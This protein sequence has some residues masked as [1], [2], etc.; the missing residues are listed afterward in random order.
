LPVTATRQAICVQSLLNHPASLADCPEAVFL[1]PTYDPVLR[2]ATF[3]QSPMDPPLTPGTAYELTV[4]V[5]DTPATSGFLSF[6]GTPLPAI[7]RFE[8]GVSANRGHPPQYD[9][10]SQVNHYCH[11]PVYGCKGEGCPRSV[12]QIFGSQGCGVASCHGGSPLSEGLGLDTPAHLA[13]T[14]IGR[15][16]HETQDGENAQI[17]D[18]S[19]PRFGRAMPV[20][21]P[22]APGNSYLVYKLLA[23]PDTPLENPFPGGAAELARMQEKIVVGMPMPPSQAPNAALLPGEPEWLSEWILQGAPTHCP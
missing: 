10:I 5:A 6:D 13:A 19:P 15:T 8:F 17:P 7:A 11:G 20:L 1:E 21:D 2:E 18:E 3:R 16:A 23:N 22:A 4:F 9:V 14:A 12:A